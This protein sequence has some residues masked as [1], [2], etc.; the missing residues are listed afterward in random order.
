MNSNLIAMEGQ[1][2]MKWTG[3]LAAILLLPASSCATGSLEALC[4][5]TRQDRDQAA[6][7]LLEEGTDR[8]VVPTARLIAKTDAACR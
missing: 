3:L 6:Q 5:A 7:A 2:Q 4:D 1:T 8:V